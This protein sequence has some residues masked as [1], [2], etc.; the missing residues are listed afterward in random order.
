MTAGTGPRPFEAVLA[1]ET[2]SFGRLCLHGLQ[3]A[4][5]VSGLA[6]LYVRA[7]GVRGGTILMYHS[8]ASEPEAR[9]I[10][11]R[12]RISPRD[13]E[14]QMTFLARSRRVVSLSA[15]V[16]ALEAGTAPPV[17]TVA[18]TFDDGYLDN[19]TVAFPLL[20]RLGLPAT[21][22]LATGYVS[23][24]ENQWVDQVFGLFRSRSRERVRIPGEA[25]EVDL[26][27]PVEEERAY[28]AM[29]LHLLTASLEDRTR[30]IAELADQLKPEGR[31]P[32]LTIT[33]DEV[34]DLVR[35]HP[36]IELGG[37]TRN[38]LDVTSRSPESAE[39]EIRGCA[40]DLA[41]ETGVRPRHFSF[42]YGR[43]SPRVKAAVEASG[44]RSAVGAGTEPLLQAGSD[45]YALARIEPPLPGARFRYLT[46][47][48]HPGLTRL[49]VGRA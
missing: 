15:L 35:R 36:A 39:E 41:T 24:G 17:G 26:S 37:H 2:R 21:I 38:H 34:R 10:D 9:W 45:R 31:P 27:N 1:R 30:G 32:R 49:L 12:Y 3:S 16:D 8:V 13:F 42:P 19:L 4:L 6:S 25:M 7:R 47:G 46:S 11:P 44:F 22:F 43:W 23:R 40:D 29:C 18:I 28:R 48:A 33:W 20:E 14:R 5:S